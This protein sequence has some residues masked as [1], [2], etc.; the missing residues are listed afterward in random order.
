MSM[1]WRWAKIAEMAAAH[2]ELGHAIAAWLIS[3]FRPV[4]RMSME[5]EEN[6]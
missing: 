6:H 4:G 1:R 2:R 3:D 5:P